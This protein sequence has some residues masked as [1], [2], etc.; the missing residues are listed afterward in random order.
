M[1]GRNSPAQT[2]TLLSPSAVGDVNRARVLG[3]LR[4]HGP[5]SRADLARHAGVTRATIGVIVGSLV[6]DGLLLEGDAVYDGTVGKPAKPVWF[7]PGAAACVAVSLDRA[8]A[9]VAVVDA[10]GECLDRSSI[11]LADRA[12]GA[13]TAKAILAAIDGFTEVT[14]STW[15]GIGVAVPGL[16]GP[17]GVILGSGQL[18][19]LDGSG[20]VRTL[21]DGIDGPVHVGN[22]AQAQAMGEQWFGQGR[23]LHRFAAIQAGDGIGAGIVIDGV[24]ASGPV[25]LTPEVGH[26]C[27][28]A[29]PKAEVC[30]CG[31]RGCWETIATTRWVLAEAKAKGL[32]DIHGPADLVAVAAHGRPADAKRAAAV[33]DRYAERL[34]VGLANLVALFGPEALILHGDVVEGGEALRSRIAAAVDERILPIA[35]GSVRVLLSSLDADATLLGAAGLVLSAHF[36]AS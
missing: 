10:R 33:L 22:D 8:G 16:V 7:A 25:G 36:A 15:N 32:P 4:D 18:P 3:V 21:R 34:G 1:A 28:D 24:V 9:K 26:T 13:T 27:V 6:D 12:S 17:D 5:L 19:G 23:G 29:G 2:A 31:L 30:R 20:L 11:A 14:A 35:R